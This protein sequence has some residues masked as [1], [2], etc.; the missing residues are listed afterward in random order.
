MG[1]RGISPLRSRLRQCRRLRQLAS[2]RRKILEAAACNGSKGRHFGPCSINSQQ[3][4]QY[5]MA[6]EFACQREPVRVRNEDSFKLMMIALALP[7]S[8]TREAV[9][10]ELGA[11]EEFPEFPPV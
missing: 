7:Q 5:D 9:G 11:Y 4:D 8:S 6:Y 2:S 3:C 10:N 1:S